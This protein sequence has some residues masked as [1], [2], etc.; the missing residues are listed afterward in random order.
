M[1]NYIRKISLSSVS[2]SLLILIFPAFD[3]NYLAWIALVPMFMVIRRSGAVGSFFF[4]LLTGFIFFS[5]LQW[6]YLHIGGINLANFSLTMLALSLYFGIFGLLANI[7]HRRIPQWDILTFPVIWT[8]L[9]YVR[10]HL[11]FLSFP[12]GLLGYSQYSVLSVASFGAFTGVYGVSFLI[13]TV[14]IGLTE[15]IAPMFFKETKESLLES[16]IR[17]AA[18]TSIGML[19]VIISAT[20]LIF[21]FGNLTSASIEGH[22]SLPVALVQGNISAKENNDNRYRE[23]I[24]SKYRKLTLDS[25]EKKPSLVVWPSSSVPGRIPADRML[26]RMLGNLAKQ[27]QSFLLI[28][29][30][31]FE[32]F[33]KE[34]SSGR[35]TANSAF[36][37][38]PPGKLVGRYDKIKL[39]PFDEY[40][41][42]RGVIKWPSWIV[43]M[44]ALDNQPGREM[45]VFEMDDKRF[46][47][48]ICWENYFTDNFRRA[49][50]QGVDF[51]VSMTNEAFI[52][53]PAAHYQ[54][55][56]MNI[57]R[58]IENRV[59]IVRTASTGVSCVV[60]PNGRVTARIQ[61]KDNKD[62]D[63]A[64]YEIARIP[65]TGER[66]FYNRHGDWF[67]MG[68]A[69][70]LLGFA[71]PAIRNNRK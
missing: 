26:V 42:L 50:A 43:N 32:K 57:F 17:P 10:T 31:G 37:F 45:T 62:I 30:R 47:V 15:L 48:L 71:V 6:W 19:I 33:N 2:A 46:G 18:G 51:M 25:A 69:F 12:W 68:L 1:Y 61:N 13:V 20:G 52:D 63:I 29:S 3:L 58:A 60:E 44:D 35:R 59:S 40:V 4:S 8:L 14:N 22:E 70:L 67:I 38:S 39:L 27:S 34:S 55:L 16:S 9:E 56:A 11:G 54:M 65:V 41:P 64:G 49:A 66:S 24:I 23:E 53:V 21:L 36:L 7:F 5:G 28:G